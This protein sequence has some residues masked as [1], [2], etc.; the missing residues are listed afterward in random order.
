MT[1]AAGT[2]VF[3]SCRP[4]DMRKGMDGLAAQ[5]VTVIQMDPY[6]GHLFVF[7]GKRAGFIKILHWDGSGLCLYAKRMEK[8]AFVWP[9]ILDE[10]LTLT[11]AQLALLIEGM[12]WRRTVAAPLPPRPMMV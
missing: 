1:V 6:A 10:S 8:D 5:V 9:P 11:A 3:L 7:R 4:I 2:K 12:D